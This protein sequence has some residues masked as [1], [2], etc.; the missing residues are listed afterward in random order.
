MQGSQRKPEFK[1]GSSETSTSVTLGR[2]QFLQGGFMYCGA[3]CSSTGPTGQHWAAQALW[4]P[5]RAGRA[6]TCSCVPWRPPAGTG[7]SWSAG[8]ASPKLT[9]TDLGAY[10]G[11]PLP[12]TPHSV[13]GA[14]GGSQPGQNQALQATLTFSALD[15][16]EHWSM[17][18]SISLWF[19]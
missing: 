2:F 4:R 1:K 9:S 17:N 18:I 7:M 16:P 12:R 3:L 13:P 5:C 8:Q 11:H 19:A 14:A 10:Q 6:R 15:K